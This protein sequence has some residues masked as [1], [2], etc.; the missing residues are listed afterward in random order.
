VAA[1]IAAGEVIIR[2]A[3]AVKELVEK[4]LGR[5]ALTITVG[6]EEGGRRLIRVVMTVR[7]DARRNAPEPGAPRHQQAGCRVRPVGYHHPGFRGRP[8]P[9]LRR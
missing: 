5:R 7:H 9:P 2:P 1:K 8:W 4:R 3:A 6:V